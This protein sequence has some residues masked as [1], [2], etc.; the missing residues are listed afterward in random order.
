MAS[1]TWKP[2]IWYHSTDSVLVNTTSLSSPIKERRRKGFKQGLCLCKAPY[3][4]KGELLKTP[5]SLHTTT[6]VPNWLPSLID[7]E[8]YHLWPGDIL[9]SY[10]VNF[11]MTLCVQSPPFVD[12]HQVINSTQCHG[13]AKK[14]ITDLSYLSHGHF[15][16]LP[17][18][19]CRQ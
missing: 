3:W 16:P 18:R 5:L 4:S 13:N 6:P 2:Y 15:T 17:S 12:T 11:Q 1:N 14:I 10:S 7:S 8:A 9:P 19:R